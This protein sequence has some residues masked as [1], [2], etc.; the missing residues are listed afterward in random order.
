MSEYS[1]RFDRSDVMSERQATDAETLA[2]AFYDRKRKSYP[3]MEP[4]GGA[5]RRIGGSW[6]GNRDISHSI[7]SR[8][9]AE[10]DAEWLLASDWLAQHDAQVRAEAAAEALREAADE[11]VGMGQ[12]QT[13]DWLRARADR[14]AGEAE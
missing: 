7:G 10:R 11:C 4:F 13:R 2:R 14:I 6:V 9:T 8:A 3:G 12:G 5:V 1:A